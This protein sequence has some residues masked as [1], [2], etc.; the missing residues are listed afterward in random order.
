MAGVTSP[1]LDG[2]TGSVELRTNNLLGSLRR[3]YGRLR[4]S[5]HQTYAAPKTLARRN[6]RPHQPK[7]DHDRGIGSRA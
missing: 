5:R 7:C 6:A 2:T 4:G 1:S 3:V